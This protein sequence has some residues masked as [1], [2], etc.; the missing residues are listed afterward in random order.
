MTHWGYLTKWVEIAT[1]FWRVGFQWNQ[2]QFQFVFVFFF[3][4]WPVCNSLLCSLSHALLCPDSEMLGA[5]DWTKGSYWARGS[6]PNSCPKVSLWPW[7][8][9]IGCFSRYHGSVIYSTSTLMSVLCPGDIKMKKHGPCPYRVPKQT[10]KTHLKWQLQWETCVP[11]AHKGNSPYIC[12]VEP[13]KT[14]W[15]R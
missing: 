5:S 9:H 10:A 2:T 11:S 1:S 14:S 4:Q 13:G 7:W 3:N 8:R 12:L 6:L 15:R